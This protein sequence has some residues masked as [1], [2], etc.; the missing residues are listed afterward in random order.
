MRKLLSLLLILFWLPPILLAQPQFIASL[1]PR[2]HAL[3]IPA[4][5]ELHVGL[6]EALDPAS[7]SDSA[8]YIYSDITGLHKWQATLENGGKDIRLRPKHWW[9]IGDAPFNAGERVTVT[10]TTRLRYAD[11]RPFEGFIWH[12]T[13]AVRQNRGGTFTPLATFG[14]P[15]DFLCVDVN[16]DRFPD[17]ALE[18]RA[19]DQLAIFLNDG[20]GRF[21]FSHHIPKP[22]R[23]LGQTLDFDRNGGIDIN[24]GRSLIQFND[25]KG[26]FQPQQILPI[27]ALQSRLYDF[28][29]DGLFDLVTATPLGNIY[30][31]PEVFIMRSAKGIA[32]ADTHRISNLP[33]VP[34]FYLAGDSYDLNND[35]LQDFLI[36]GDGLYSPDPR[37]FLSILMKLNEP[38]TFFQLQ[39]I[40]ITANWF[41]QNDLNQDGW[42]DCVFFG[43]DAASPPRPLTYVNAGRGNL[44]PGQAQI[45]SGSYYSG[46][47]GGD[48]DGDGD[49]DF[50]FIR[51]R[52]ISA[53][54]ER[55]KNDFTLA[56]NRGTGDFDWKSD[57]P[58]PGE[59]SYGTRVRLIDLDLDGDLDAIIQGPGVQMVIANGSYATSVEEAH[60]QGL[61]VPTLKVNS[62]PNPFTRTTVIQIS[63][64]EKT[65]QQGWARIFDLSGRLVKQWSLSDQRAKNFQVLW[66][67]KDEANAYVASGIY[68]LQVSMEGQLISQT[69]KIILLK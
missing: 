17:I 44:Q 64:F 58:L 45:D 27:Q 30:F 9:G 40:K 60:L 13:V 62:F 8:I 66:D 43:G 19:L 59:I 18:D 3:N 56:L 28:N 10:L 48:V 52:L 61:R 21:V 23:G 11:G 2:Q 31:A 4:D 55:Y 20:K 29:N 69:Q 1:Y 15:Y 50:F 37:G 39:Q 7:L 54:P 25:G 38:P 65:P 63:A 26:N 57:I 24:I 16:G 41:Y 35:G 49:I 12:Y 42:V 32:Y 34:R 22:G 53:M 67:G 68:M 51:D 36:A 33:F 47:S 46:G 14:G 6:R 5:D